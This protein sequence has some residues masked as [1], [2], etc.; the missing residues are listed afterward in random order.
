MDRRNFIAALSAAA[1]AA[2]TDRASS[3]SPSGLRPRI[4]IR[5]DDPFVADS[6]LFT[7]EERD[8]RILDALRKHDNLKAALFVAGEKVDGDAGKRLLARW[9]SAGHI[10][11]NHSYSHLYYPSKKISFERY[12]ED[13]RQCESM[14]D[15]Y[16]RS[17]K[18]KLFGFPYLKEGDTI[19]KRDRMRSFLKERGYRMGYATIDTSEWALDSRLVARL[20]REPAADL[21]PYREFYLDHLWERAQFYDDLARRVLGRQIKHTLLI[22]HNLVGALFLGDLLSMFERKGWRWIDAKEAYADP[23]H[24]AAPEIMPA[25][26]SIVYALA[27]ETKRFDSSLRYPA[28]DEP[29]E[30]AE[31]DRRGL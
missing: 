2:H 24:S 12:A 19:E 26:E 9:N 18:P 21:K 30:R 3:L 22:H 11:A 5:M 10:L 28:E 13:A 23:I 4:A 6:P 15:E 16:A 29:Y 31:M 8:R 27:K 20:K 25:G 17:R 1:L 14:L 7:A